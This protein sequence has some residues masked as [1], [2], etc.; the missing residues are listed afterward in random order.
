MIL[1]PKHRKALQVFWS[2]FAIL[3]ILSMVLTSF[4]M[5]YR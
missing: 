1:N 5:L 4:A 2:I 3:I